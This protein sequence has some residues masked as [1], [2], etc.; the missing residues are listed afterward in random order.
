[1]FVNEAPYLTISILESCIQ[2][3]LLIE[4]D[5]Q[6]RQHLR[7]QCLATGISLLFRSNLLD[8][9]D[10]HIEKLATMFTSMFFQIVRED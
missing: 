4:H 10:E 9:S 3:V 5:T 8:I 2:A 7:L 1:M 6:Q